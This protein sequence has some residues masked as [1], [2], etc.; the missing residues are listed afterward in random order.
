MVL[1]LGSEPV[2]GRA[3]GTSEQG[4]CSWCGEMCWGKRAWDTDRS[5]EGNGEIGLFG[6]NQK[7]SKQT[8]KKKSYLNK[9][10]RNTE[11]R[12]FLKFKENSGTFF[13]KK[14]NKKTYWV[15]VT[16]N[17]GWQARLELYLG[18]WSL[19]SLERLFKQTNIMT[20]RTKGRLPVTLPSLKTCFGE[21]PGAQENLLLWVN[22]PNQE[23]RKEGKLLSHVQLFVTPWTIWSP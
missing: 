2:R 18:G 6:K 5:V 15:H 3:P 23:G 10:P 22:Q 11:V 8:L 13:P 17:M 1:G 9:L 19:C 7:T 12:I 4:I 21:K 16:I 20:R 14:Q